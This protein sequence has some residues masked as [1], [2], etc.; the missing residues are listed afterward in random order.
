MLHKRLFRHRTSG[1]A[2]LA[3]LAGFVFLAPSG[4]FA[5]SCSANTTGRAGPLGP[6]IPGVAGGLTSAVTNSNLAFLSQSTAFVAGGSG[7]APGEMGGGV[8]SRAVGGELNFDTSSSTRAISSVLP[9]GPTNPH[10]AQDFQIDCNSEVHSNFAGLQLGA[11]LAKFNLD[12]WNVHLGATAGVLQSDQSVVGGLPNP[13][14]GTDQS[15]VQAPFLGAYFTASKEGFYVDALIRGDFYSAQFNSPTLNLTN[16]TVDAQGFSISA[17][18]G[19]Q[20]TIP[21]TKWFVEPSAGVIYSKVSV[22]PMNLAGPPASRIKGTLSVDDITDTI[23]RVGLRVGTSFAIGDL[24]LQPFA[25]ASVWHDFG[26]PY[27]ANYATCAGITGP[28]SGCAFIGDNSPS[29]ATGAYSGSNFG[30]FGQYSVG[31]SGQ[32]ANTGWLGFARADYRDGTNINGWDFTG[33]VRYQFDDSAP[34]AQDLPT[35]KAPP[36]V[37]GVN[38]TGFYIGGFAGAEA[39]WSHMEF[40]NTTASPDPRGVL[41]G[42]VAGYNYQIGKLVL[43]AEGDLGGADLKGSTGCAPLVSDTRTPLNPSGHNLALFNMNCNVSANWMG[44][45]TARA[46]YSWERA[47]LYVKAGAALSDQTYS[48]SCNNDPNNGVARRGQQCANFAGALSS[49]FS[50]GNMQ[51]LGWTTG[52]GFE[53]ALFGNWSTKAEF[54]YANFGSQNIVASDGTHFKASTAVEALKIG[55]NYRF[56]G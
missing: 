42:G 45:L 22:D 9:G 16:Q 15:T 52:L 51:R 5:A 43:G 20:Y 47:L 13:L 37:T 27:T 6:L 31:V 11:D 25:A 1:A 44:T 54:D 50:S 14:E 40:A 28:P 26:D 35:R 24:S 10:V 55:L 41:A 18:T 38:W 12:G 29:K 2:P 21:N 32:L 39:G 23:G 34:R 30:T 4:A 8:W 53:Y 49:G 56:G 19:Y 17:S 7:A 3:L 48:T 33:G 36:V 46:G